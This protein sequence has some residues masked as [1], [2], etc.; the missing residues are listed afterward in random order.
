MSEPFRPQTMLRSP[1]EKL[2]GY[3]ILP[4]LIDKVRLHEKK[5]LPDDYVPNL[6]KGFDPE[7]GLFP[8]DGRFLAFVGI[9]PEKLRK[10][11]LDSPDDQSVIRGVDQ[12][13]TSHTAEEKERWSESLSGYFSEP[14]PERIAYRTQAFPGLGDLLG[15]QAL[16]CANSFDLIDY[17]EGRLSLEGLKGTGGRSLA[18]ARPPFPPLSKETA[19]RKVRLAEDAWNSKNPEKVALA[20]TT[21]SQWRNRSEFLVGRSEI[22]QFL[23][24]K[25]TKELDYRLIKELWAFD[26]SRIAVLTIER[27]KKTFRCGACGKEGL[28]GYDHRIQ[29]V[30]HLLWWEHPTVIRFPHY[31][32]LCPLC[33]VVTEE[34]DFLPVRGPRVTRPLAHLAYELCKIT[35]HKAVGLLL[36][37]HRGTVKSI[38]QTMMEKVQAERPLDGIDVLGFDEIASGKGQSYW[39]MI[40]SPEGPRGPRASSYRGR[41]QREG[42]EALLDLVWQRAGPE[43]HSCRDG[44]VARLQE[45]LSGSLSQGASI[46]GGQAGCDVELGFKV[47]V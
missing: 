35:T 45:E 23:T 38:D 47:D 20:Y 44:H 5:L 1:R 18:E 37:L 11:I 31:R 25:W 43:G 4:R 26:S 41:T 30:R 6:L 32:V 29:E 13:A 3:V 7:T 24:R 19:L 27:E 16:G 36:G 33:G 42:P 12:V 15:V 10:T 28:P 14:T 39:T 22:I 17:D 46:R 40:C 2:G 8:F 34:L 9:D 21:D